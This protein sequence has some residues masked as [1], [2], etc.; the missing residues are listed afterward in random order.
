MKKVTDVMEIK[1]YLG[2]DPN[3]LTAKINLSPKQ[4]RYLLNHC[5]KANRRINSQHV[6]TLK[7]DMENGNWYNDIDYIGFNKEGRLINGQHR[8][9]ALSEA[10]VESIYLKFDFEAEQHV[11]M[12]TGYNRKY[13]AQVTISNK[14]G[15]EIMPNK[16]KTIIS[17]G[18]KLSYPK[19][20][21]SN[22]EL[23]NIWQNYKNDF[24]TCEENGLFDLGSKANSVVKS[25]VFLAYI[26][27]VNIDILKN[28]TKVLKSGITKSEYDIPIIRLR[29]ELFD[30]RGTSKTLDLKRASYTQQCI[31]NVAELKSTSNRL[32]SNPN[33]VY[34]NN[35]EKFL[36]NLDIA[37]AD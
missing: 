16:F 18:V 6:E 25:S 31:Y 11:S 26:D 27:G 28:F 5:N 9:K 37:N 12:D 21:L 36:N 22:S 30:L 13:T 10:N 8:L 4:A 34:Q 14:M 32:P 15:M 33:L 29:D 7:R 3:A 24:I 20:N 17:S 35:I 1:N 23:V 2:I 19:I